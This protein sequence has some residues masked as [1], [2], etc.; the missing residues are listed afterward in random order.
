MHNIAMKGS[1]NLRKRWSQHQLDN[2][3]NHMPMACLTHGILGSTPVDR[4][5][6]FRKG[7]IES[8]TTFIIENL[9]DGQK[10]A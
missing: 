5:H 1:D 9:K 10:A 7:I 3:F 4:M 8:M 2:V 6:A